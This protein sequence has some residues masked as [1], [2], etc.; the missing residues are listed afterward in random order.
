MENPKVKYGW[1]GRKNMENTHEKWRLE[2]EKHLW[3][4]N[5]MD[6]VIIWIFIGM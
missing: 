3:S 1:F 6:I 5:V 2:W 4:N